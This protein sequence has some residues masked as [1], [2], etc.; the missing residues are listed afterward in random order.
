M[1][2]I[3]PAARGWSSAGGQR[4]GGPARVTVIALRG[5]LG[6]AAAPD[7]L[8]DI[9]GA[10]ARGTDVLVDLSAV[11]VLDAACLGAVIAAHRAASMAGC[12]VTL[13]APQ[14][15]VRRCLDRAGALAVLPVIDHRPGER[16]DPPAPDMVHDAVGR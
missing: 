11:T 1:G 8:G 2:T 3:P 15:Q 12:T 6:F 9:I 5:A 16:P 13:M 10:V 14:A 4:P 7:L